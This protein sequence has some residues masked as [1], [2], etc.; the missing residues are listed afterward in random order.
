MVLNNN[1][2]SGNGPSDT[3]TAGVSNDIGN[4]FN[5][6]ALGTTAASAL[7]NQGNFVGFPSF[8]TPID[9]R[10]GSDGPATFFLSANYGL[11]GSSAA[12][13]N[14]LESA[15]S[16]TDFLGN[17]ENPNPVTRGFGITGYGPRD[18]GAFEFIPVGT[19]S[20]PV[21]GSFRVVTTSLVPDGLTQAKGATLSVS[22]MPNTVL[23]NFSNDVDA[24]SLKANALSISGS[25]V[26][27]ATALVSTSATLIDSH[28]V[29]FTM[30]GSFNSS[31]NLNV[32]LAAGAA[33]NKVGQSL[34]GYTDK[35]YL[36][37]TPVVT[38]PTTPTTTV[39]TP[40]TAVPPTD[41]TTPG[42]TPSLPV[43]P[44]TPPPAAAPTPVVS[45]GKKPTRKPNPVNNN[46][47]QRAAARQAQQAAAA[48]RRAAQQAA[49]QAQ[50]AARKAQQAARQ[51][52]RQVPAVRAGQAGIVRRTPPAF[53]A[54]R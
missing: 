50:Q 15:A 42:Q 12:I 51:A 1:M 34:P 18:V 53:A 46:A 39:V 26:N 31:G 20:V 21:G 3:T 25:G 16:R 19:A 49:R 45:G 32:S 4:G 13:N 7:A 43:A 48:A 10:P 2:F 33:K 44:V 52:A 23:V 8:I 6:T 54:Q 14:A 24:S 17:A 41:T 37:T 5:P 11:G 28:T 9:P 29:K 35:V 30:N 40:P 38:T 27:G 36:T 22:S 47:A